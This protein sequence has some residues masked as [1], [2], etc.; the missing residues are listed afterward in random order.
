MNMP[1]VTLHFPN[2]DYENVNVPAVPRVGETL[3]WDEPKLLLSTQWKVSSVDWHSSPTG[4]GS[5]SV[6]LDPANVEAMQRSEQHELERLA[7]R[8]ARA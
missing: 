7:A 1:S 4:P 2:A 6:T 8:D 5:V 3:H